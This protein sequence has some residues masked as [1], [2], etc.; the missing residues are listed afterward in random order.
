MGYIKYVQKMHELIELSKG[1]AEI[2]H[3]MADELLCEIIVDLSDN[4]CLRF[5]EALEIVEL[6]KKIDKHYA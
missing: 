6:Y 2:A 4:P 5:S 3:G 1:D